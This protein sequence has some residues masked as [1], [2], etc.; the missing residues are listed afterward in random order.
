MKEIFGKDL[1]GSTLDKDGRKHIKL[2]RFVKGERDNRSKWV[3]PHEYTYFVVHKENC[4][5][6]RAAS[7]L[8]GNMNTTAAALSYAGTKDK[9][10]KTT[11]LFCMRKREP[12]KIARAAERLPNVHVGNFTFASD[13]LKLGSL[14]GNQFRIALR[15]VDA[16]EETIDAS[17]ASLKEAGFVNYYG[18]QRF[19]NCVAIP[20]HRV[21][22]ALVRGQFKEAVELV[23]QPRDGDVAFM[24]AVREHWWKNRDAEAAQRMLFKTN[25]GVEAKLLGGLAKNGPNDY[26]NA[27][28]NVSALFS[29]SDVNVFC[30]NGF[31]SGFSPM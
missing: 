27:L 14:R 10:G 12:E 9:R 7:D 8:A 2:A 3:W 15:Q 13:T 21:G 31:H 23:L 29:A 4:D 30:W 11:Q 16:D 26:V 28:E 20:T 1:I 25:G 6:M 18:L 22:L 5:T 19:G 24:K 17:L